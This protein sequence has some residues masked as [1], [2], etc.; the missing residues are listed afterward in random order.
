MNQIS[1]QKYILAFFL[2]SVIAFTSYSFLGGGSRYFAITKNMGLYG[3][4]YKEL[5]N[6]YVDDIE[7][8]KLMRTG[9]D[10]MLKSLDPY[11]NYI[12]EAQ[13]ETYRMQQNSAA[14]TIGAELMQY[15]DNVVIEEI[16]ENMG[17]QEAGLMAGDV[18]L[19]VNGKSAEGR[20]LAEITQVLNGQTDTDVSISVKRFGQD[21]PIDAKI[22]RSKEVVTSV[23]YHGLLKDGIAYVKLKTF[24]K[25]GC[26]AEVVKAIS[27][28]QK[29]HGEALKG[30]VFDLRGNGGGLLNEAITMVNIFVESGKV[31]VS[32]KGKIESWDKKYKT[33]APPSYL[34]LPLTVLVNGRSASASE[35]LAGA[36][37]D[38]DRG[39]IVGQRSF[40]KGLVQQSKKMNIIGIGN[41]AQIKLTVAK[42]FL[43]SGRCVQALD[44]S[45]R[46]RDG[47]ISVP[48]SLR[49]KFSTEN[50]R[51]VFDGSGVEPDLETDAPKYSN[52]TESLRK[53]HL[54]FDYATQFRLANDSIAPPKEYT[55]NDKD[56]EAFVQFLKGKN[57]D[58]QTKSEKVLERLRKSAEQEKYFDVIAENLSSLEEKIKN[59]KEQDLYKFKDELKDLLQNEIVK[60]YYFQNGYVQANL[61]KDEEVN[62]AIEVLQN[63]DRYKEILTVAK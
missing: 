30:L 41:E 49:T 63:M 52:V 39:V 18:I 1:K 38:L 46:Y 3:N 47:T 55:F 11:T 12:S 10:A 16:I 25:R 42:Y 62:Q 26:T 14:G 54:I 19:T 34:N 6:S 2:L 8:S 35:I 60:R 51:I 37:Q 33:E 7:P 22:T 53:K 29:E 5:N 23:P 20:K 56:F 45:G 13:I 59:E 15:G 36:I 40:G 43:P 48:D 4:L 27:D 57:Y 9:M 31:V 21:A 50:G 32:T 24:L 44:Y 28:V 58:Y 61:E 17:A